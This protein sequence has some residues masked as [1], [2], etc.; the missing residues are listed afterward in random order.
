MADADGRTRNPMAIGHLT[1]RVLTLS[2]A[3]VG[4]QAQAQGSRLGK[5]AGPQEALDFSTRCSEPGHSWGGHWQTYGRFA[6]AD[7]HAQVLAKILVGRIGARSGNTIAA[8]IED[9]LIRTG[10]RSTEVAFRLEGIGIR[11]GQAHT[12]AWS[13]R[14]KASPPGGGY[15]EPRTYTTNAHGELRWSR[16]PRTGSVEKRHAYAHAQA[17]VIDARGWDAR[18]TIRLRMWVHTAGGGAPRALDG[19][20]LNEV[21]TYL[22]LQPPKMRELRLKEALDPSEKGGLWGWFRH[23]WRY[24]KCHKWREAAREAFYRS[25]S[26][27]S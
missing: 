18:E 8:A 1:I 22:G 10:R 15:P 6:S 17:L 16:R 27:Q 24:R 9:A 7:G 4:M 26:F 13:N 19:P 21:G 20:V 5:A 11:G 12:S 2:L 25:A 23:A 3:L 14:Y